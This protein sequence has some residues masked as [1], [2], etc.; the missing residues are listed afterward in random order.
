MR[1]IE[2]WIGGKTTPGSS[3]RTSPVY[4]PATG[5]HRADVLLATGPTPTAVASAE[6]AFD[7]WGQSSLS[8]APRCSSHSESS[9]PAG[10]DLA[11]S[12]RTSTAKFLRRA[13]RGT[14]WPRGR[15]VRLRPPAPGQGRLLRPGVHRCRH[16]QVPRAAGCRRGHHAVQLPRDGPDVDVPG[17]D[18]LRQHLRPQAQRAR[19]VPLLCTSP[20]CGRRPACPHG[21]FNVVHGDKEAVDSMLE[22]PGRGRLLRRLDP[23]R[24]VH[25]RARHRAGKRVQALGGA[26]NHA[27]VLPDASID[28]ASEHLVAAAFGSAGERFMAISA[29]VA[30]GGGGDA[31]RRGDRQGPHGELGPGLTRRARWGRSSRGG[32]DR[33]SDLIGTGKAQGAR[34]A[35]DGRGSWCPGSRAASCRAHRH[36]PGDHRDG[37]LSRGDLRP[38]PVVVRGRPSTRPS[39]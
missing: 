2:H 36:R 25:P 27:I 23:D 28:F 9:H 11:R 33:I 34:L 20:S 6:I 38:R 10:R 16:L 12:S 22:P 15:G 13:R 5:E 21:V 26:K 39:P 32:P 8:S 29:A 17:R 14:A 1:T 24:E 7:D 19:P 18:R 3:G 4:D 35:V 30:V 37:R 31:R